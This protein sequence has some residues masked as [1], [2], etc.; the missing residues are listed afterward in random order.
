MS[1]EKEELLTFG[2]HLEV[3]RRMFLRVI[4][5]VLAIAVLVFCFK[6]ETFELL[7]APAKGDFCLYEWVE[8]ISSFIGVNFTFDDFSIQLISTE[9]SAQFMMHVTSS[10]Y[11]ALL[12]ASP[13]MLFELFAFIAPALYENEKR[14]AVITV[15]LVYLL[16][17]FGVLLSYF[18][19]FPVSFRFLATYQVASTVENTITLSSYISTFTTLTLVMGLV[20]QMPIISFFLAKTGLV[21]SNALSDYRRHAILAITV[22]SAVITPPDL[23][24]C[25]LVM[26]PLYLLYECSIG[27]MR[28]VERKNGLDSEDSSSNLM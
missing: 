4:A 27:I 22:L 26:G 8:N 19:L 16:F 9:L 15:V 23:L 2:G 10:I 13:Y 20:F 11:L 12:L 14:Y 28:I 21:T 3:L 1:R 6:D 5:A 18:V 25:I 24:T 17:V 7:L